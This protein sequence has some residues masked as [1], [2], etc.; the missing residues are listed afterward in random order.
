MSATKTIGRQA[1]KITFGVIVLNGEPFTRYSLRSL[2]PFA[3]QIV[4]VEGSAPGARAI[5]RADGHS[6][7]DTLEILR[8]FKAREDPDG[9]VT[10][11]TAE[12]EGHP[13]GTWPGEKDEQSRAFA[14]RATGDYLWQVDIDEFYAPR[15]VEA[16]LRLLREEP[17]ITGMSFRQLS[18]WG[19]VDYVVDGWYLSRGGRDFDRLFKW[20]PGY[21]YAS[22]RPPTVQDE[23]GA[24][25]RLGNWLTGD[26]TAEMGLRLFHYSLLFPKQ[27]T[28]KMA[29][30]A[31]AP[32]A[33]HARQSRE[34]AESAFV[35]LERPFRVHNVYEHPSWL[36][37]YSGGHPPAVM[38]M[39]A[40]VAI[41]PDGVELRDNAD[42]DALLASPSYR[43]KRAALRA[44]EPW[45]RRASSVRTRLTSRRR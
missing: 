20:G 43:I 25:L 4:V 31:A 41:D 22:H 35:R 1:P 44:L 9:K 24:N 5:A 45:D 37:R 11:V 13:D 8:D 19:G 7:D 16:T 29:Y 12:A 10:I 17:G 33:E 40:D 6:S 23:T 2:Y 42:V 39:M 18:F 26:A 15:D 3:H 27:V 30:Y 32:W 28:E 36:A 21:S 14:T 38:A 34:W